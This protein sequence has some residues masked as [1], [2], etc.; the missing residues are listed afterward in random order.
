MVDS[1]RDMLMDWNWLTVAGVLSYLIGIAALFVIPANRKPGEAT[2]WLL[3]IFV[4][5]F[6][7]VILFL[8]LGSP[9]LS[10]WRR[11]QQK[12]MNKR[13][14][15]LAEAAEE[16]PGLRDLV[17][18]PV[19]ARYEPLVRLNAQ[20]SGMP[21]TAGNTIEVLT[22]YTGAVERIVQD[23]DA[24]RRYVHLEYFMFY[25]DKV[26]KPVLDALVRAKQRGVV[27]RVLIDHLGN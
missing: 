7:G 4:A 13:I 11:D 19:A 15:D 16:I 18:P 26:G 12:A 3:L 21:V 25:E 17:D 14:E 22:D 1:W 6:L 9:D 24:A 20:L 23:I 8:L 10:K 27:C 5:P 2:A